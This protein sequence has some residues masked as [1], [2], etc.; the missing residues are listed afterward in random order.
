MSKGMSHFVLV[1]YSNALASLILLPAAFFFTRITLMQN[2]VI[3]GVRYSSPTLASALANLI[4]AFTFLL[5]VIFSVDCWL[6]ILQVNIQIKKGKVPIPALAPTLTAVPV[7]SPTSAPPYKAPV[8]APPPKGPT[9]LYN[10][11]SSS[12]PPPK[13]STPLYKPPSSPAPPPKEATPPYKPPAPAPSKAPTLPNKPP[14]TAAPPY[15]A[16]RTLTTPPWNPPSPPSPPIASLTIEEAA[17]LVQGLIFALDDACHVVTDANVFHQGHISTEGVANALE[18]PKGQAQVPLNS[19][20]LS[21][22]SLF[23]IC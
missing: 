16:P 14:K 20:T 12:A 1:I 10:P 4:P 2:C 9:P 13:G 6:K 23:T 5:A 3:I 18:Y 19:P 11:P 7:R 22:S 8:P 17:Y 15:K 21:S